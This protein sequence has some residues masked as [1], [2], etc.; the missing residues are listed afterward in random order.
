MEDIKK[1]PPAPIPQPRRRNRSVAVAR[2]VIPYIKGYRQIAGTVTATILFQQLEYWFDLKPNGFYKFLEPCENDLCKVG[3]S[4]CEELGFSADE[5]RTAFDKIGKRYFSKKAYDAALDKFADEKGTTKFYCSYHDKI[6]GMTYYYRNHPTVDEA[7]ETVNFA[8]NGHSQSTEMAPQESTSPVNGEWQSTEVDN[9]N[10]RKLGTAISVNRQP[11]PRYISTEITSETTAHKE[12]NENDSQ[13][14]G[15]GVICTTK[16]FVQSDAAPLTNHPVQATE[17]RFRAC[18]YKKDSTPWLNPDGT[19]SEIV[20]KGILLNFKNLDGIYFPQTQEP[21]LGK[22]NS[23]LRGYLTKGEIQKL[24]DLC[25]S[26]KTVLDLERKKQDSA[27][28]KTE[29]DALMPEGFEDWLKL[30][31][32]VN[33]ITKRQCAVKSVLVSGK[34]RV[35]IQHP[36]QEVLDAPEAMERY[37][38]EFWNEYLKGRQ[39]IFDAMPA[40]NQILQPQPDLKNDAESENNFSDEDYIADLNSALEEFSAGFVGSNDFYGDDE[41]NEDDSVDF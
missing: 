40:N 33:P 27:T 12:R 10:L 22:I 36:C 15:R 1:I 9:G 32:Q 21:N 34:I 11:Q 8:V 6:K 7:I 13:S 25:I 20:I 23:I 26:G 37:P 28:E 24:N 39:Q 30:A 5:F 35:T 2:D 4:W 18:T 31:S 14:F 38:I 41:D 3:D 17:N 19:F 16:K 29:S